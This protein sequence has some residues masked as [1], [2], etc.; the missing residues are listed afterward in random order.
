[1]WLFLPGLIIE[2]IGVIVLIAGMLTGSVPG[3]IAGICLIGSAIVIHIFQITRSR[4]HREPG[5]TDQTEPSIQSSDTSKILYSDKLV[6]IT[7]NAITFQN[8][9]LFL[10]PRRVHFTDIDH[11]DVLE[12]AL[13][14]GKYRMWGSGDFSRWF[15]L[16]SSRSSRDKIF[17]A[18]VKTRGMNIGFTVEKSGVVIPILR[19]KGLIG[20]EEIPKF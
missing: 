17:H 7:G 2:F 5:E 20:T 3:M 16:D 11:I 15:P 14:T 13:F 4:S 12:P 1:M 10:K 8:Y 6:T 19:A 18:Y 9:S